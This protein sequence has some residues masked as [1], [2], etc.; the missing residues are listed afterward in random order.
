M[1]FPFEQKF[2]IY[3]AF[4]DGKVDSKKQFRDDFSDN[5]Q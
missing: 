5:N 1:F 2:S 4:N 3:W